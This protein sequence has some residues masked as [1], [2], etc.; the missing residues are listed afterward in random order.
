MFH[1]TVVS[2]CIATLVPMSVWASDNNG[3]IREIR[4]SSGGLAEIVRAAPVGQDGTIRLE[5]PLDQVDDI[6]KSLVLNSSTASV[7]GFSLTGPRPLEESFKGL[8][9]PPQALASVPSLLTALQGAAVTV[10]SNGKTVQGKALGV[11]PRKGADG[12]QFFL[13][14]ALTS[15]GTVATLALSQDASVSVDDAALR[16][17]LV[18]AADAIARAKNDRSRVIN[19]H[20]AGTSNNNVDVSYVIASPI[21]KTAYKVVAQD[22]GNARLQAWTVLENA[23]GEDWKHVKIVLSS[24]DPVTLRQRLH[25]LY[26][27]KRYDLP[28]S[29]A[30]TNV[31]RADTGNLANREQAARAAEPA[32]SARMRAIR[33][34][35]AAPMLEAAAPAPIAMADQYGGAVA[36]TQDSTA[37]SESDISATFA[38]PGTYDLANGDTLSAPIVDAEVPATM[39]SVY[40][41]GASSPH[42]VAALMLK[43]TTGVSLPGGILTI[44]DAQSGYVGD[45]QLA[46]L[47]NEDTRL[48][49]FATDRKVSITEDQKPAD[50]V[51]EIKMV[52]GLLRLTQKSRIVTRYTVSGALDGERVVVIEH[53]IRPGWTFSSP[54]SDGKT[55]THHRL[56]TT[57]AAGKEQTLEA[58][59]EQLQ[60]NAY[61]VV[62]TAPDMLLAW[63]AS[64]PDKALAAKLVQLA[65]ARRKQ[66]DAQAAL[67]ALDDA[68]E[69]LVNEQERIRQNLGAVPGSSDLSTRYLK[70][71]ENSENEIRGLNDKRAALEDDVHSLE[72]KVLQILRTF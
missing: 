23:S 32:A 35:P 20:V 16:D 44:Y 19:I 39:V 72:G 12:A 70:Q 4:L 62:D 55:A 7:S 3:S 48:A 49:S 36:S 10:T 43:N 33:P 30:A 38:L 6:L 40:Q 11:E 2:L 8:P 67:Q 64:S 27:K 47:P 58:V 52:D 59:D 68:R 1:R 69:R 51:V 60:R 28:I 29:T 34:A 17:K 46:G 66:I 24:A 50:E 71:L 14:S 22:D 42:P 37:A 41:A 18:E 57:V 45:A 15:A 13:L 25:Q 54:A 26:W 31:P 63:S 65:E 61:A 53:P 21:W 56:K 5:V 9:F